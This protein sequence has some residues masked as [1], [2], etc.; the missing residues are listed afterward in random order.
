M[1]KL[2]W[3]KLNWDL[4]QVCNR[5]QDGACTQAAPWHSRDLMASE[6]RAGREK[7]P[8]GEISPPGGSEAV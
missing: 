2:I 3:I 4:R 6:V 5:S 1:N 8:K 7:Y